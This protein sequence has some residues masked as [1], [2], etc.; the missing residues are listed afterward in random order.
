MARWHA[1]RSWRMRKGSGAHRAVVRIRSTC[2]ADVQLAVVDDDRL[3]TEMHIPLIRNRQHPFDHPDPYIYRRVEKNVGAV[4][5]RHGSRR[6]PT[7]A[8]VSGATE[9]GRWA[10][11]SPLHG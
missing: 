4:L 6:W 5:Q 1:S 9:D 8:G 10:S 7:G 3:R 11:R 2:R